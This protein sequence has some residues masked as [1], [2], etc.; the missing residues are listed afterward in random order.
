MVLTG[1]LVMIRI[2]CD[3]D[4]T[5]TSRDSIVFLTERFGGGEG[6]RQDI[7]KQIVS[8]QLTVF[9]A[10]EAELAT[11]QVSWAEAAS[12]LR[13]NIRVDP[14]FASFVD[15][16]RERNYYLAVVS[17]GMLPVIELFLNS[18]NIPL[19]AHQVEVSQDGWQYHVDPP[20]QKTE[21]LGRLPATDRVIYVGDGTSDVDVAPM[22]DLLFATSYLATYCRDHGIP[23]V[24]FENF[25]DVR[26]HLQGLE[27][28]GEFPF[29]QDDS[30]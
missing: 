24:P 13:A 17:S 7:F 29:S 30:R 1:R 27:E 10:I 4:G 20:M 28:R 5:I 12:A 6:F 11:V 14:S 9:Q 23:F 3:F 16:S 25:E 19:F 2:Y 22:V 18:L 15:W 8:G 26:R 21:L